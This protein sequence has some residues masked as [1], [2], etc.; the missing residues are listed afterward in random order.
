MHVLITALPSAPADTREQ[1]I[2][3]GASNVMQM[4]DRPSYLITVNR[5]QLD[6]IARLPWV[7]SRHV[8]EP[9][10]DH[11]RNGPSLVNE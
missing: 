4:N 6:K 3:L 1:L 11:I 9:M 5:E 10:P 7:K 2:Q 8:M